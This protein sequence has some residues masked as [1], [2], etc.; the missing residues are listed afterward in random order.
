MELGWTIFLLM[1]LK[2]APLIAFNRTGENFNT[3]ND[4]TFFN[5]NRFGRALRNINIKITLG[6]TKINCHSTDII[7][8]KIKH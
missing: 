5:D 4:M 8:F 2:N 1:N 3:F 7:L 6:V